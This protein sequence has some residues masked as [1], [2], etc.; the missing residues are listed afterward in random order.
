[1]GAGIFMSIEYAGGKIYRPSRLLTGLGRE[2]TVRTR[3][4]PSGVYLMIIYLRRKQVKKVLICVALIASLAGCASPAQ[5]GGMTARHVDIAKTA[6]SQ[7]KGSISLNRVSGGSETNPLWVSKV[8]DGDFKSALE[9]SLKDALLL[10]GSTDDSKYLLEVKLISLEQPLFGFDLMVTAT[11]E[12]ILKAKSTNEVLY[13]KTF[14]T[15]FTAT[16]SDSA[17][18]IQRLRLANEGAVRNNI[19]K[20]I[21]DLLSIKIDKNA[22]A[23]K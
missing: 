6:N 21:D 23:I 11:A 18:A 17:M 15:P 5:V 19:E 1:V 3:S 9:K 22:V 7:T 14:V 12:Y 8:A 16:F 2:V 20:V 10:S 13:S 4:K